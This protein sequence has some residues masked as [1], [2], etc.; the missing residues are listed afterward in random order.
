MALALD[1]AGKLGLYFRALPSSMVG[2]ALFSECGTRQREEKCYFFVFLFSISTNKE[3]TYISTYNTGYITYTS[4]F[5]HIHIHNPSHTP[6]LSITHHILCSQTRT[7]AQDI[8]ISHV[9]KSW[10]VSIVRANV[11]ETFLNFYHGICI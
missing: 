3:I 6:P 1:K 8:S 10:F 5:H 9:E 7:F 2:K 11:L 4:V